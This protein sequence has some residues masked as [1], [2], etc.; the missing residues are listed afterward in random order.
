MPYPNN[1]ACVIDSSL[2]VVG[3]QTREHN[4]KRYVVRI[5]KEKGA[6]GSDEHS[7]L[8]PKSQW[9]AAEASAH[10]KSHGGTFEKATSS[11]QET[12]L[13]DHVNPEKNPMIK[14]GEE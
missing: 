3:S 13:P 5:G 9:T 14:I 11:V 6:K 12:E 1:H 8:Y 2:K 4:G 10:C 7:Y